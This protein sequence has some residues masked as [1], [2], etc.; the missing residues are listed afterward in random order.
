MVYEQ[1]MDRNVIVT[2]PDLELPKCVSNERTQILNS[3]HPAMLRVNKQFA[4][5]YAAI[6]MPRM[7]LL[8]DWSTRDHD[9]ALEE[10]QI[11]QTQPQI[12]PERLVA[13]L[14]CLTLRL[15]LDAPIPHC[16]K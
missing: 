14:D 8:T 12:L 15:T 13:R 4:T 16:S 3:F 5:E 11:G 6:V 7:V 9:A 1:F 10:M 2:I